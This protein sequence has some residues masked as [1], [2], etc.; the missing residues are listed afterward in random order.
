M[1][2]AAARLDHIPA[3]PTTPPTTPQPPPEPIAPPPLPPTP[4]QPVGVPPR[5]DDPKSPGQD[6]PVREPSRPGAPIVAC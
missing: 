1:T 6:E 2:H 4:D 3:E 5:I